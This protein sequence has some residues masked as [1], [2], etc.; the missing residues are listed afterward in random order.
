MVDTTPCWECSRGSAWKERGRAV[1]LEAV[2]DLARRAEQLRSEIRAL[3]SL[4]ESADRD[5]AAHAS[6]C[7]DARG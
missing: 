1:K 7:A 3:E 4:I 2:A 5:V 6:S